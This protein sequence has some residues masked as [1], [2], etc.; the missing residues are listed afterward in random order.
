MKIAIVT[1]MP[2][3]RNM[4]IDTLHLREFS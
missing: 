4:K 1:G 2:A 3:E